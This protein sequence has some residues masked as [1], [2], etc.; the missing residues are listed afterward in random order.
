MNIKDIANLYSPKMV[1]TI[2]E[3]NRYN[4]KVCLLFICAAAWRNKDVYIR[5]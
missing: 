4:D 1:D 2:K 3:Q 5:A